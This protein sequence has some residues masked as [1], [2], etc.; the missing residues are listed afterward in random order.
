LKGSIYGKI[1][2]RKQQENKRQTEINTILNF[3]KYKFI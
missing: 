2:K 1:I 3:D